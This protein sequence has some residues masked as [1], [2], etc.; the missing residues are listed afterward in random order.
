MGTEWFS[1]ALKCF[2]IYWAPEGYHFSVFLDFFDTV[3][4]N[5][6]QFKKLRFSSPSK[7]VNIW[8]EKESWSIL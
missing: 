8:G 3:F 1:I 6:K 5:A 2:S 7:Y 4:K